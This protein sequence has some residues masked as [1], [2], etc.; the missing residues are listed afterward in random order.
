MKRI[1]SAP[2]DFHHVSLRVKNVHKA[3]MIKNN[4]QKIQAMVSIYMNHEQV[5]SL[6]EFIKQYE[7]QRDFKRLFV[8]SVEG[9]FA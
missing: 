9:E 5:E 4:E 2:S 7:D 3:L 1:M 8:F 6:K